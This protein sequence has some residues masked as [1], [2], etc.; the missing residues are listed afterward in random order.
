MFS[1]SPDLGEMVNVYIGVSQI[2]SAQY[3]PIFLGIG[4]MLSKMWQRNMWCVYLG[5]Q[6]IQTQWAM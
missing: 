3:V 5:L 4:R 6:A 1:T 2:Y